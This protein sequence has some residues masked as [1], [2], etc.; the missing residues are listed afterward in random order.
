VI[1][2]NLIVVPVGDSLLYLQPVYLQSTASSFPEFQR[3]I[4]ASATKVVWAPSLSES[5]QLLLQVQGTPSPNPSPSPSPGPSTTPKPTGSIA[6]TP[7]PSGPGQLPADVPGLIAYANQHFEAAQLALR[8]GDFATY[9]RE[10]AL[11]QT[12]LQRLSQLAPA[13]AAP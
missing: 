1:R 7:A 8:N 3:I 5:L 9:G 4:V 10:I 6:P 2:G 13:S 11:V 12:A